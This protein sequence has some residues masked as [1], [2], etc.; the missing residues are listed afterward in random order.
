MRQADFSNMPQP[1]KDAFLR[2]TPDTARLR[3]MHE[4]DAE[5]MRNFVDVPDELVRSVRAPTLV[6]IGDR[7]IVRPE[8]AVELTRLI[9]DARLLILPAGHGDYLGEA[10]MTQ[11]ETRQPEAAAAL[12]EEF[13][14]G[15]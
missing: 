11:K 3:T 10:V 7:D 13:L 1:L 14:D 4:K 9:P 15:S 2:V 6:V 8:H 5:R 12:I